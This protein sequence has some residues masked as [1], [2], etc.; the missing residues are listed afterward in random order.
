[1]PF[2]LKHV[3]VYLLRDGD[4]YTLIDTGLQT[5]ESRQVLNQQLAGLK[6]P[7]KRINR[8][9]ITHIH[10]DHFGLAGELR[11]RS[12]AE[13]IIHRLEVETV[14]PAHGDPFFDHRGRIKEIIEHHEARKAAL[15]R[16]AG[17]GPKTGWQLAA[18]LFAGIMQRN[19]FQQRLALQE[20]LAHCQS[21]AVEG[22]L[23]KQ[24]SRELVT[25]MAA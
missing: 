19:V 13:L 1:M 11:E 3:N 15:V 4:A 16:L 7:V 21:L 2:E 8:I 25:W 18:E 9:L 22:R 17:G 20:T 10:P 23:H 12:G 14:L 6:V 24:V 5:E